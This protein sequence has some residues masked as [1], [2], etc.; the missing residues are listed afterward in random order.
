MAG[1]VTY[2]DLRIPG[3]PS[4]TNAWRKANAGLHCP[5]WH[6]RTLWI[7]GVI[8]VI[9]ILGL[10]G[11]GF[12]VFKLHHKKI[13]APEI[14]RD[15][16]SSKGDSEVD[17]VSLACADGWKL[18]KR[19]CYYFA[20][21]TDARNWSASHKDCS[22][23]DSHL[24]V[25]QDQAVLRS[26]DQHITSYAWIGL[27]NTTAGR[28]WTWVNGSTLNENLFNVSGCSDG[29]KCAKLK[30]GTFASDNC[31]NKR[32]WIC[33]KDAESHIDLVDQA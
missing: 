14:K 25:I 27:F 33:Q 6:R 5:H 1:D 10:I 2:A 21:S 30:N 16:D 32:P 3:G 7:S 24:L 15:S 8:H 4:S 22:S 11:F 26:L 19:K 17:S 12:W 31:L 18:I 28:R 29:D 13:P 20:K 9:V 23:R